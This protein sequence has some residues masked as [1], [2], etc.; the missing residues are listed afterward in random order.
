MDK[1]VDFQ[2]STYNLP[3][4]QLV[5]FI[6]TLTNQQMVLWKFLASC[7]TTIMT[8]LTELAESL[9]VARKFIDK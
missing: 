3:K 1:N 5:T 8:A 9:E 4:M 7:L 2:N 6:P